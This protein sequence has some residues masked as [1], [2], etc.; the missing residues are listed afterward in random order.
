MGVKF[1]PFSL[2]PQS[3]CGSAAPAAPHPQKPPRNTGQGDDVPRLGA[4]VT[5]ALSYLFPPCLQTRPLVAD[6]LATRRQSRGQLE[7]R[8]P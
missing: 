4:E 8:L 6:S 5:A 1:P 7:T 3:G 2:G